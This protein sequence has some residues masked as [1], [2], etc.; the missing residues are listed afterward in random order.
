MAGRKGKARRVRRPKAPRGQPGTRV[1]VK[2][3]VRTPR[4]PDTG[5]HPVH[6]AGYGRRRP[7][8]R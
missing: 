8:R 4:G 6:V 1:R 5:K 2:G 7:R 3:H